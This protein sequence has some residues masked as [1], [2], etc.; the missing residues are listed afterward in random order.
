M[1]DRG[2]QVIGAIIV[3]FLIIGAWYLGRTQSVPAM[4]ETSGNT[5][6][7]TIQ[8]TSSTTTS[9]TDTKTSGAAVAG[10]TTPST[11]ASGESL[12]VSDQP[13]GSS[14]SVASATLAQEDWIA[15]RESS[16]RVLG[17]ALFPVGTH[18]DVTVPLL[19]D[20]V[21]GER[22]QALIYIDADNNQFDLRTDTL[23]LNSDGSVA[24]TMFTA[25]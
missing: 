9:T 18:T 12:T 16:G 7:A 22:Y 19:R 15:I 3:A 4:T 1:N 8:A 5:S 24:G 10:A 20:T 13:A 6:V 17:A 21:S 25:Q 23:V 2:T 14:V 11:I